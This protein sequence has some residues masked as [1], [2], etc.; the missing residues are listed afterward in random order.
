MEP[1]I[2]YTHTADGVAIAYAIV[3]E[4]PPLLFARPFFSPGL[5]DELAQPDRLWPVLTDSH[6]VVLWDVRGLGLSGSAPEAGFDDWLADIDAV[7]DAA[8]AG[9]FDLVGVTVPSHLAMAYAVR[10]PGKVNRIVLYQPTPAGFSQ[11]RI[12]PAWLFALA[13]ENWHDFV[14]VL[15]LRMYGWDRA[16]VAQR[17]A[18]RLRAHFTPERFLHLMDVLESIDATHVAGSIG[19]PT[20]VIDD[21]ATPYR[22]PADVSGQQFA[23]QLAAAIPGAQLVIIKPGDTHTTQVI[24]RFLSGGSGAAE[25]HLEVAT[26]S[27]MTAIL[28][29][30]IVDSTALT[31]RMGD[32]AFRE[33]ARAL[34][35]S[36]RAIITEA[37]GTTIDAKTLGDGV[38]A[39]FP[40]ASQAIDAALRCGIAGD[41]QSLPLHLGLHAGDV[42]R[43]QNNVFGGAVNIASRISALSAPGEVLVSRTVAD[44]ARTSAGVTFEDRGAHALKGVADPQRVY[45]VR[46]D[47]A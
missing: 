16:D 10:Q 23:R 8:G 11:R 22:V 27:G 45:A 38:L 6:S 43:E 47:G 14:D 7:A 13:S 30:D 33:R 17:W 25:T 15:A 9:R 5:D 19:A 26:P 46:K 20:L 36:L 18:D 21:R 39:T 32:A 44:L 2:R 28:F 34:D 41:E 3:G 42:I 4:G 24:E 40:A 35:A 12:Q 1:Q 29:A 31:E 37:G